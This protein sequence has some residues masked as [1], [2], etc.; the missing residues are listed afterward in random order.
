MWCSTKEISLSLVGTD[1]HDGRVLEPALFSEDGPEQLG[2]LGGVCPVEVPHPLRILC[3]GPGANL[4]TRSDSR[5]PFTHFA[6]CGG[7]RS[8]Y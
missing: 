5:S 4:L 6:L 3:C 1:P 8:A 7:S 2:R